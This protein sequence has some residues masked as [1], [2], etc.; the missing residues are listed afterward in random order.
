MP[1]SGAVQIALTASTRRCSRDK[2]SPTARTSIRTARFTLRNLSPGQYTLYAYTM[3]A[4]QQPIIISVNGEPCTC[5]PQAA[6]ACRRTIAASLG[7]RARH[8]RRPVGADAVVITLQPGKSISGHVLFDTQ[9]PLPDLASSRSS[10]RCSR[11]SRRCRSQIGPAPSAQVGTDGHFNLDSVPPGR[12]ILRASSFAPRPAG[13]A[14]DR[15]EVVDRG[16]RGHAR[17][18]ARARRRPGFSGA[19]SRYRATEPPARHRVIRQ[20]ST[21]TITWFGRT[22]SGRH[23][24][25]AFTRRAGVEG[26]YSSATF[27]AGDYSSR[28][29]PI[30]IPA[31][32]PTQSF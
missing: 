14:T 31:P 2:G 30:S 8:R 32:S 23:A 28:P 10:S 13:N 17:H 22:V 25:G 21:L 29:S 20:P 1:Q 6:A 24:R 3:P 7:T 26:H 4:Q 18:S 5:S 9:V 12:C 27:R 19:T 15:P 11:R 16:R